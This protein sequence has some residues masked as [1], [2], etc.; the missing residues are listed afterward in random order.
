MTIEPDVPGRESAAAV[1]L[2]GSRTIGSGLAVGD[3]S[4]SVPPDDVV[5]LDAGDQAPP[6]SD[7]FGSEAPRPDEPPD[8]GASVLWLEVLGRQRSQ[9]LAQFLG[10]LHDIGRC[11]GEFAA[12][13]VAA[14]M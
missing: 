14:R 8:V 10:A 7:S 9:V 12:D 2:F 4:G 1:A 13:L 11:G 6:W 5:F 3:P